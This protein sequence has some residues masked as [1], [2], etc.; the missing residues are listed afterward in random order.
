VLQRLFELA[1]N[2]AQ[3]GQLALGT[4]DLRSSSFAQLPRFLCRAFDEAVR[5]GACPFDERTRLSAGTHQHV[6]Q[7]V[8]VPLELGERRVRLLESGSKTLVLCLQLATGASA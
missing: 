1:L 7:I 4:F 2:R 3:S 6:R 5:F 8:L